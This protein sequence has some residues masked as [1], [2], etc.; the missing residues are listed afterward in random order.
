MGD[1]K[2]ILWVTWIY[3]VGAVCIYTVGVEQ[4]HWGCSEYILWV[5][6]VYTVGDE[7]IY[8]VYR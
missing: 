1:V 4:I 3:T 5:T 6:E 2:Y 8:C 7:K